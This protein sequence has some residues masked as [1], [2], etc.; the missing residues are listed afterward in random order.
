[1]NTFPRS[2]SFAVYP[3]EK[4]PK[5]YCREW[6]MQ[7]N[8]PPNVEN[9]EVKYKKKR[10]R[11]KGKYSD[12]K[13][14]VQIFRDEIEQE[15]IDYSGIN[16]HR[17]TLQEY[18]NF[19]Y[20][21]KSGR[22]DVELASLQRVK[23]ALDS[24]LLNHP[25]CFLDQV[26]TTSLTKAL[27][28]LK[29]GNSLSKNELSPATLS[30]YLMF[31]KQMFSQAYNDGIIP[32][33]PAARVK[34]IKGQK[35]V[36]HALSLE[37][38]HALFNQLNPTQR[39]EIG[40]IISLYSGLRQSEVLNLKW[41]D[42]SDDFRQLTVTKSKTRAGLRTIP[43]ITE[44]S[45]SL[46][47]RKNYVLKLVD[48]YNQKQS[49]EKT[50]LVFDEGWYVCSDVIGS[51]K[52]EKSMLSQWWQRNRERLGC[53]YITFHELRHTYATLLAKSNVHPSMMQALLGH[54]TSRMSMEVYTH[55]HQ[56]DY[57]EAI[58]KLQELIQ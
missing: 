13:I 27:I 30:K 56:D 55:V 38:A 2:L 31:W 15:Y 24:L 57:E 54:S 37:E 8:L 11:F 53:G 20:E 34:K 4:K 3:L 36:K 41:K 17:Y 6:M 19:F 29:H 52:S 50:R 47:V 40:S 48:D 9:G 35:P 28:A 32:S 45:E 25:D 16:N 43:L 33:N 21:L 18:C 42:I 46:K 58:E 49:D 26:S 44:V 51:I 14:A 23:H 10:K 39:S 7:V 1:M 12:A 22:E 5:G